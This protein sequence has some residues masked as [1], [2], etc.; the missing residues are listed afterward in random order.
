MKKAI[1]IFII[2]I[3]GSGLSLSKSKENKLKQSDS[4]LALQDSNVTLLGMWTSGN[5]D[6]VFVEGKYAYIIKQSTI[7]I[8]DISNP[9]SPIPFGNLAL[10]S[11]IYQ[12]FV[13]GNYAYVMRDYY[14]EGGITLYGFYIINV[15]D[16]ANP[17]EIDFFELGQNV[18]RFIDVKGDYIYI[19]NTRY[20]DGIW[21]SSLSVFNVSN[22][23][24]PEEVG[25][26]IEFQNMTGMSNISVIDSCAYSTSYDGYLYKFDVSDPE[27]PIIIS[28][29]N[30]NTISNNSINNIFVLDKYAYLIDSNNLYII[31]INDTLDH[32]IIGTYNFGENQAGGEVY[33]SKNY[34]YIA[35]T[36]IDTLDTLRQLNLLILDISDPANPTKAGSLNQL[37]RGY[38]V[39]DMYVYD[40][41]AYVAAG[42]DGLS[43]I[44]LSD[45]HN[46]KEIQCYHTGGGVGSF[47]TNGNYTYVDDG[48]F[49]GLSIIDSGDPKNLEMIN[50]FPTSIT[51]SDII[52]SH[53]FAYL[54]GA[55]L[56]WST[57]YLSIFNITNPLEPKEIVSLDL[58]EYPVS[59][60]ISDNFAYLI[61][62]RGELQIFD[63]TNPTQIEEVSTTQIIDWGGE[64]LISG[65]FA[66]I[67][68]T[69]G[70][71]WTQTA[72]A[73][74]IVNIS[75][76]SNPVILDT[77]VIDIGSCNLLALSD[78]Y[79]YIAGSWSE[80]IETIY[81]GKWF[82]ILDISDPS[83][84]Y[85]VDCLNLNINDM[86]ITNEVLYLTTDTGLEIYN[87]RDPYNLQKIGNYSIKSADGIMVS[88]D[89]IYVSGPGVLYTLKADLSTQISDESE[90]VSSFFLHQNYPNPFNP[91][92]TIKFT[93]PTSPFYPSPYQG[94]GLGEKWVTLKVYDILGREVA[95]L[96]NEEKPAGTY[97]VEFNGA[98]LT[99]GVYF[100]KLQTGS[101]VETK[102]MM[103]VK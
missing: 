73:L 77:L 1:T 41:Y 33:V 78:N 71:G 17:I 12:I 44:D 10:D 65:N 11:Y 49:G 37:L 14:S 70:S 28:T 3:L 60:Q 31:E 36:K 100:Y 86:Y 90:I 94:E 62:N 61:M 24:N 43:I 40:N 23:H 2:I 46:P 53:N 87:A 98:V 29:Y 102:K 74:A 59:F 99:S 56:D 103:L 19:I 16:L 54:I 45:A 93:I 57:G 81:G 79:L 27:N 48:Q 34:A 91:S 101:Y 88:E 47:T 69:M 39:T 80:P 32:K 97:E 92:T 89:I 64:I 15:Q 7:E 18:H 51:E 9:E 13:S 82:H 83:K 38:W 58:G 55:S 8:L 35:S 63:I 4:N 22:P 96:V 72:A 52:V 25:R 76:P 30:T 42:P 75:V 68:S 21:F 67:A 20:N 95:T 50:F 6:G 26:S 66:Y 5:C 84:P 85:M